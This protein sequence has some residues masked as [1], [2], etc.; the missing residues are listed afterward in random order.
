[1]IHVVIIIRVVS[2]DGIGVE[3]IDFLQV[4]D[5]L[6]VHASCL[7]CDVAVEEVEGADFINSGQ[8]DASEVVSMKNRHGDRLNEHSGIRVEAR[9]HHELIECV[10]ILCVVKDF[11]EGHHLM[12]VPF[13]HRRKDLLHSKEAFLIARNEAVEGALISNVVLVVLILEILC[14]LEVLIVN[15]RL[16]NV[17]ENLKKDLLLRQKITLCILLAT[18]HVICTRNC[19]SKRKQHE[20]SHC[21][22]LKCSI[23]TN[24]QIAAILAFIAIKFD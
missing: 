24:L 5:T 7:G 23:C 2:E 17:H 19:D 10:P 16:P 3:V 4:I 14:L 9:P 22:D 20:N 21:G 8:Y 11:E 13:L 18:G 1:M 12:V 15:L 6:H